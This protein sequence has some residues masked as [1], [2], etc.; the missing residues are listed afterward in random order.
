MQTIALDLRRIIYICEYMQE[1]TVF[2]FR[3]ICICLLSSSALL[4][5]VHICALFIHLILPLY[6]E[7]EEDK[8]MA[9]FLQA[10]FPAS[11]MKKSMYISV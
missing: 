5:F 7:Q 2:T 11:T 4:S 3:M 6:R 8:E 10:K 1:M 9:E